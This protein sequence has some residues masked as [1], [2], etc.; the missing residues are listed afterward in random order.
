MRESLRKWSQP[1]KRGKL[2]KRPKNRRRRMRKLSKRRTFKTI[3]RLFSTKLLVETTCP[4]SM[5]KTKLRRINKHKNLLQGPK[6]LN[7]CLVIWWEAW[8][9]KK[10]RFI[11]Y[12]K[13]SLPVTVELKLL[14]LKNLKAKRMQLWLVRFSRSKIKIIEMVIPLMKTGPLLCQINIL[15]RSNLRNDELS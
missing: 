9:T 6:L 14:K 7:L 2:K 1:E 15:L 11:I 3:D 12:K 13:I 10:R 8:A 5:N 4:L